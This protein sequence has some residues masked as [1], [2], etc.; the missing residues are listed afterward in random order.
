MHRR[1]LFSIG[2]TIGSALL[3]VP[4]V[5]AQQV[6][7]VAAQHDA[8]MFWTV[9]NDTTLDRLLTQA[10]RG[11]L[12]LRAADARL[13]GAGASRLHAALELAPTVTASAGYTRQRMSSAAFPGGGGSGVLPDRD[14]WDSGLHASW[15]VD[16]AGR[17]RGRLR[18]QNALMSSATEDVRDARVAI[19]ADV[20]RTYFDLRGAQGQLSVAQLNAE[21]QRRTLELTRTRL[22]AGRGNAFDTERARAQLSSTLAAIPLLEARMAAMQHRL[23]VLVGRPPQELAAELSA[24]GGLPPLPD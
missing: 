12:D 19:T 6:A 20:A 17:L 24:G 10:L 15:E 16:V 1:H 4:P 9:L 5:A 11:N 18:A 2:I 14:L 23:A 22:D 7:P 13:D 8:P 3:A 21:N